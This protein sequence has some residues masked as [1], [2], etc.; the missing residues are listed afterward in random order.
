MLAEAT[1][2]A[3]DVAKRHYIPRSDKVLVGSRLLEPGETQVL[4]FVVPSVAGVY[5]Y[6]CTYPGHWRRM[7]GALYVVDDLKSYEA[8]PA[9]YLARHPLA[10]RDELLKYS[11]QDTEWKL[12]DLAALI[13]PLPHGRSFEVGR[14]AFTVASCD[15]CHQMNGSG[16]EFG[17]DLAKLDTNKFTPEHILQA[18]LDPSAEINEEFQTI[19]FLLDSGRLVTGMIVEETLTAVKV[20][21]DPLARETPIALK[22]AEISQRLKSSLSIM[23]NGL[24]SKLTREEILDLLAYVYSRGDKTN[25]LFH[26]GQKH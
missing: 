15:S 13:R 21:V 8:D 2:T 20:V 4:S 17:P 24:L 16:K 1:A 26:A 22:K 25:M 19:S 5:P 3:P 23:P 11:G 12:D 14:T 18:V 10:L 7:Y 6:V 9:A